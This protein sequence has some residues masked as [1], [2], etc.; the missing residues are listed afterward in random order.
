LLNP[1]IYLNEWQ[2]PKQKA[3]KVVLMLKIPIQ[4]LIF[5]DLKEARAKYW[6]QLS[7]LLLSL[8]KSFFL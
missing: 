8:I 7:I 2:N 3:G 5:P 4:L 1:F 6:Y